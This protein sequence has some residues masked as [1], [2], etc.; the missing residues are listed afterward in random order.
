MISGKAGISDVAIST[1]ERIAAGDRLDLQPAAMFAYRRGTEICLTD[2]LLDACGRPAVQESEQR[3]PVERRAIGER[4]P[5]EVAGGRPC[6]APEVRRR[7]PVVRAKQG[8]ETP[9]ALEAAGEGNLDDRQARLGEQLL[10][11]QQALRLGQLDRRDAELLFDGAPE[12][13]GAQAQVGGQLV[14]APTVIQGT[15]LDPAR[16][17][18][19]G[20]AHCVD[21]RMAGSQLRPA[22]Q[23]GPKAVALGQRPVC[24][25]PAAVAAGTSSRADR[26]AIDPGR[27]HADEEEAVKP[28]VTCSQSSVTNFVVGGHCFDVSCLLSVAGYQLSVT[29]GAW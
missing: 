14:Q 19:G 5:H 3:A 18:L 24:K 1:A 26:P 8:I 20:A 17:G 27:G 23:A 4:E 7:E 13:P 2:D 28:R 6:L 29:L 16:R 10:G 15:R 25:E 11:Q 22:A 21:R 9:H 12:L